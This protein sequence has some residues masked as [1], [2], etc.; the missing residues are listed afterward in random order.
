M[1]TPAEAA[2]RAARI[3]SLTAALLGQNTRAPEAGVVHAA[4][5]LHLAKLY[6]SRLKG[7]LQDG[8]LFPSP[9][10]PDP[11]SAGFELVERVSDFVRGDNDPDLSVDDVARTVLGGEARTPEAWN[12][13]RQAVF[14]CIGFVSFLYMPRLDSPPDI[15]AIDTRATPKIQDASLQICHAKTPIDA[16]MRRFGELFPSI[17]ADGTLYSSRLSF[18]SL[19]R[20]SG[21][22]I[23]WVET[24]HSHLFLDAPRRELS[25]FRFPSACLLYSRRTNTPSVFHWLDATPAASGSPLSKPLAS[26]ASADKPVA[27]PPPPVSYGALTICLSRGS[28]PRSPRTSSSRKCCC[29]TGCSSGRTK[30]PASSSAQSG[31]RERPPLG[32]VRATRSLKNCA[33]PSD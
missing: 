20:V 16:M 17:T 25:L 6:D 21:I 27:P 13:A 2:N 32:T 14:C 8:N 28:L 4:L 12:R 23:R 22:K 33:S 1:P 24:L 31:G 10:G 9:L 18:H 29:P 26:N 19:H 7:A 3:G 11:A 30:S 15:L 5:S